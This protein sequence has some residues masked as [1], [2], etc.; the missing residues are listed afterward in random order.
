MRYS[1]DEPHF[2]V[3]FSTHSSRQVGTIGLHSFLDPEAL[4]FS[5]M[6]ITVFVEQTSINDFKE[7]KLFSLLVSLLLSSSLSFVDFIVNPEVFFILLATLA[8]PNNHFTPPLT[9]CLCM[10]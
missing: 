10:L 9:L 3:P 2:L 4:M 6:T 8:V 5:L 1:V 7:E